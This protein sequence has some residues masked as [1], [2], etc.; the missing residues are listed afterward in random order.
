M[1]IKLASGKFVEHRLMLISSFM[2]LVTLKS[3]LYV[4]QTH[5][6]PSHSYKLS[7]AD[8][9]IGRPNIYA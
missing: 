8:C 2:I 9:L 3:D 5:L 4:Q 1:F 7:S 6:C